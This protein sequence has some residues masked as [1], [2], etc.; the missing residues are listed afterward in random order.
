EILPAD[1]EKSL[2]WYEQA[3]Q[4]GVADAQFQLGE[5]YSRGIGTRRDSALAA[6]WY[7]Q[8]AKQNHDLARMRLG[9]CLICE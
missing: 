9:G 5:M 1:P 7:R 4:R 8:A 2:Y 3:A 6:R